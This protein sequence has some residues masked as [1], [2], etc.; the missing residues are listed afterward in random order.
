MMEGVHYQ[1][2]EEKRGRQAFPDLHKELRTLE[3]LIYREPADYL[4]IETIVLELDND[5]V[6]DMPFDYMQL[7]CLGVVKKL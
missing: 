3:D 5:L 2:A 1:K 6:L 4:K 7:V